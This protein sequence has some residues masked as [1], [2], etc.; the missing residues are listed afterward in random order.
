MH[1]QQALLNIPSASKK[2]LELSGC[3]KVTIDCYLHDLRFFI[4]HLNKNILEVE[5]SDIQ[6]YLF[7]FSQQSRNSY[8]DCLSENT[9]IR[10]LLIFCFPCSKK[11]FPA[12]MHSLCS[13]FLHFN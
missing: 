6:N 11:F 7:Y 4:R 1:S 2:H 3:T 5:R 13:F 9:P 8:Y 10:I 12:F